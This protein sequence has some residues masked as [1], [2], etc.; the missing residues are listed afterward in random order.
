[1]QWADAFVDYMLSKGMSDSFYWAYTPNSND[2]GG[3]L[4]DQLRVRADKM[5]LLRR[6]WGTAN[7][8][9]D[10]RPLPPTGFQ[11]Q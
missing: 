11:V 10:A 7:D 2:V 1:V 9:I 8:P 5:T 6:L 3:I 4:D